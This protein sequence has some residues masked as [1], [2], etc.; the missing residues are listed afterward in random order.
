MNDRRA[1]VDVVGRQRRIAQR[2]EQRA[3][4]PLR[5]LVAGFDGSLTGDRRR[6]SLVL[7]R[8]TGY[9]IARQ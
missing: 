9:P 7:R 2:R 3:H 6:E 8:R 1:A 4:F 5:Q